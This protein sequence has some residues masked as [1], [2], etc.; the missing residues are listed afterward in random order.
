MMTDN[1]RK[2]TYSILRDAEMDKEL[3]NILLKYKNAN[4]STEE[5][6]LRI[7][8]DKVFYVL[9]RCLARLD[10]LVS[11]SFSLKK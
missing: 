10:L 4:L 1:E 2:I 9:N 8:V 3:S 7:E 5:I 6:N 11:T